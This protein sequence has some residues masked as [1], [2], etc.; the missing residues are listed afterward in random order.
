M[1]VEESS[2]IAK[3]LRTVLAEHLLDGWKLSRYRLPAFLRCPWGVAWAVKVP[4]EGRLTSSR[5]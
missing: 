5:P 1:R 2:R 4:G 3:S